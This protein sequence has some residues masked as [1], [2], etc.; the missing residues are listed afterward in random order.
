[1]GAILSR[2]RPITGLAATVGALLMALPATSIAELRWQ[3]VQEIADGPSVM[4]ATV[5]VDARGDALA[6]WLE[7][8]AAQA[9]ELRYSWRTPH[10]AW[11]A[12]RS[13]PLQLLSTGFPT[14]AVSPRGIATAV[15]RLAD[16]RVGIATGKPG[17]ALSLTQALGAPDPLAGNSFS[18][19]AMDDEGGAS[20]GWSASN[21]EVLVATRRPGRRFRAP[22]QLATDSVGVPPK[23]AVNNAG[24]A[25]VAWLGQQPAKPHAAYRLPGAAAFGPAED[26][27]VALSPFSTFVAID[28]GGSA[29]V[30]ASGATFLGESAATTL[31]AR[32]PVGSFG[33]PQRIENNGSLAALV[34]EPGGAL[35]ILSETRTAD[36]EPAAVTITG[37]APSGALAGPVVLSDAQSCLPAAASSPAGDLLVAYT[38]PCGLGSPNAGQLRLRRSATGGFDAPVGV[39]SRAPMSPALTGAGEGIVG[40]NRNQF[41]ASSIAFEDLDRPVPPLPTEAQIDA[42]SLMLSREGKLGLSV[43]CPVKCKVRPTGILVTVATR[44]ASKRTTSRRLRAKKRVRVRVRFTRARP[45]GAPGATARRTCDALLYRHDD[46][47]CRHV[48]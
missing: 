16:G 35:S 25:V 46:P 12:P 17:E 37:R 47:R 34:P 7:Q 23:I 24:A 45:E 32:S 3:P 31:S 14:F 10:G 2:L 13:L 18:T 20:F 38:R 28:A 1:M 42:R 11:G 36:G 6:M 21:G 8:R 9:F 5:A 39:D 19:L 30:G 48:P 41:S 27:P 33:A 44:T 4:G 43:R 26:V 15:Y 40:F 22:Q 29:V